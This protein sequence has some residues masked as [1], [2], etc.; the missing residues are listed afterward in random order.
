MALLVIALMI[1]VWRAVQEPVA[2]TPGPLETA[3]AQL[4]RQLDESRKTESQEEQQAWNS[5]AGLRALI[6]G[7]QQRIE[8]LKANKEAAEIL[9]Y[10]HEAIDR[11]EK[12]IAQIGEEEAARAQAA[13]EAAQEAVKQAAQPVQPQ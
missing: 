2:H 3:R 10:D 6:A 9:T 5:P 7:H 1:S 4:H 11:L 8:K 12:R 13:K